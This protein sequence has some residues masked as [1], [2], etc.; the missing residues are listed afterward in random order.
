M[1]GGWVARLKAFRRRVVYPRDSIANLA[2][3]QRLILSHSLHEPDERVRKHAHIDRRRLRLPAKRVGARP[4]A[5]PCR[6]QNSNAGAPM[7][8]ES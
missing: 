6:Q 4:V 7:R 3:R 1:V 2:P 5:R 8:W